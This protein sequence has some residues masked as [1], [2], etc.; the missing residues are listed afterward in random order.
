[1]FST[2]TSSGSTDYPAQPNPSARR[3]GISGAH[4]NPAVTLADA[5]TF[6]TP[7]DALTRFTSIEC[8][9]YKMVSAFA[10]K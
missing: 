2:S 6:S 3:G 5:I 7:P 9:T 4:F 8:R 10:S 1:M